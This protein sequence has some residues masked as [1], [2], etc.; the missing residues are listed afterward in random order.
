MEV[1]E[2]QLEE[3]PL[4]AGLNRQHLCQIAAFSSHVHFEGG[5]FIF[6]EGEEARTC[7]VIRRGLVAL[8]LYSPERGAVTVQTLR[9]GDVL[10]LSWV[11]P[12]HRW[13]FSARALELTRAVAVDGERLERL[14]EIDHDLGYPLMKRLV[15]VFGQR[16]QAT[17]MQLVDVYAPSPRRG[18]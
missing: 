8:Q 18:R 1:T 14:C 13:L 17:R 10:G 12:P 5:T 6:R 7:Y 9:E 15:E 16:L 4:F 2:Q 3:L 11:F